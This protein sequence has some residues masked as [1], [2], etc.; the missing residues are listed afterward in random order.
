MYLE[1]NWKDGMPSFQK[2]FPYIEIKKSAV[3]VQKLQVM[4]IC[5]ENFWMKW[6]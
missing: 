3:C 6:P 4:F 2:E 1:L 5:F